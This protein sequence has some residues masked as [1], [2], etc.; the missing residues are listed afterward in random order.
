M[1]LG[2]QQGM[3]RVLN[4]SNKTQNYKMTTENMVYYL[5]LFFI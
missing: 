3:G 4:N 2:E 1:I 5:E